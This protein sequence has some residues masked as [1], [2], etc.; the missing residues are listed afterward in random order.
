M[1]ICAYSFAI[2]SGGIDRPIDLVRW[3]TGL[4]SGFARGA[5]DSSLAIHQAI[6]LG[7]AAETDLGKESWTS[8]SWSWA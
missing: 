3:R 8:K 7:G 2:L 1:D 4:W 5:E 6:F